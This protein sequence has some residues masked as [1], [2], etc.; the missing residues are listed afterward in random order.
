MD[1]TLERL[2]K[3]DQQNELCRLRSDNARLGL[4]VAMMSHRKCRDCGNVAHHLLDVIP[5]VLCEKCG[6]QDTR[7]IREKKP[8]SKPDA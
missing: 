7:L 5:H 2:A 4:A 1:H 6:S 3:E 8:E